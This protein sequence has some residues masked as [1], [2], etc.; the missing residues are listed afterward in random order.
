M[1]AGLQRL[2]ML[3]CFQLKY[4]IQDTPYI[5]PFRILSYAFAIQVTLGNVVKLEL[6]QLL[7]V[8]LT[9][10]LMDTVL[11]RTVTQCASVIQNGSENN[12][13]S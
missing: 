10:E 4:I 6:I 7:V 9:V 1:T 12:A 13:N 5:S 8:G 2:K 11:F 3:Q